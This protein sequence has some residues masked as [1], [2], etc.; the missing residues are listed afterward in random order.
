MSFLKTFFWEW[1]SARSKTPSSDLLKQ[2]CQ[3]IDIPLL[4]EPVADEGK[5]RLTWLGHASFLLQLKEGGYLFDPVFSQRC[6]PF[7]FAGPQ[8]I[9]QPPCSTDDIVDLVT[10]VIL[11]HNHYDHLDI[12]TLRGMPKDMTYF[13][14]LG[15]KQWILGHISDKATVHECDWWDAH[16]LPNGVKVT[17]LPSQHFSGRGLF[18]RCKTLWASW[19]VTSSSFNYYFGGYMSQNLR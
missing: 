16:V 10:A 19:A 7:Q 4:R 8:R 12:N 9:T 1:D 5:A 11:S 18:D 15:M 14:P 2:H 17:C 13:V 3:P 6:S